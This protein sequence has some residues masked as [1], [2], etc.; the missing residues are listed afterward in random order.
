M[1][2]NCCTGYGPSPVASKEQGHKSNGEFLCCL[3]N[4]CF[5]FNYIQN[6]LN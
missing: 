1:Y 6:T 4:I 3:F 5:V 2:V